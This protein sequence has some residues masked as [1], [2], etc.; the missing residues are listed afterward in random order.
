[1]T[2]SKNQR[3]IYSPKGSKRVSRRH[4]YKAPSR[5]YGGVPQMDG[6]GNPITTP[7]AKIT[8]NAD[9]SE[10]SEEQTNNTESEN[11]NAQQP[12]EEQGIMSRI[13]DII[14]GAA[15]EAKESVI[16][17][18]TELMGSSETDKTETDNAE[19]DNMDRNQ[20]STPSPNM[21]TKIQ[22]LETKNQELETKIQTLNTNNQNQVQEIKDLH[23]QLQ[24][25][26]DNEANALRAHISSLT[27]NPPNVDESSFSQSENEYTPLSTDNIEKPDTTENSF[28]PTDPNTEEAN[29]TNIPPPLESGSD[30]IESENEL[31]PSSNDNIETEENPFVQA[32][33]NT[34]EAVASNIPPPIDPP[35]QT[36]G[37]KKR[38][39]RR[40]YK[41]GSRN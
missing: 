20:E 39:T 23:V 2:N 12:K 3:S 13:G 4:R 10:D 5:M 27:S 9:E 31:N 29:E 14:T 24:Q 37:G 25:S 22:E 32:D 6:E 41:K 19:T 8:S 30:P 38:T 7:R 18:G 1:M 35:R 28:V 11:T 36:G 16:N 15:G 33:P 17:E 21:E 40:R 26:K 34:E